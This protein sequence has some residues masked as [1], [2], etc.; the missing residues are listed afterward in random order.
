MNFF[1]AL[2]SVFSR[3]SIVCFK[4]FSLTSVNVVSYFFQIFNAADRASLLNDAFSLAKASHLSYSVP[5][6]LCKYIKSENHSVPIAVVLDKF[7]DI[8][9]L[10]R[11]TPIYDEFLV[12]ILHHYSPWLIKMVLNFS[13]FYL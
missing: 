1:A 10:L 3:H 7:K 9:E 13:F 5:L 11:D 12:S 8:K 4:R 6:N 2:W